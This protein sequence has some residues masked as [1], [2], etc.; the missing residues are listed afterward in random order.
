MRQSERIRGLT[1]GGSDGWDVFLKARR[2]IAQGIAVTELTIGEHDVRTAAPILQEMHRTAIGGHTGYAAVPGTA[3]LRDT[4][5]AR[6]QARTGV[7]TTRDNVV[8]TP[9]GQAALFAAHMAACDPGDTALYIDPYYA[10]YPGTLRGAGAVPQAIRTRAEDAF[11]PRAEALRAHSA[12]AVSLLINTPNNPTGVVYS[13]ATLNVVA[14]ICRE[15]DLWLIS[16][17]VY[18]TQVW[19]GRHVSPRALPGMA[20]RTL[21]VGSMSKSHA[22]TGS[23]CG[24]IVGPEAVI[25]DLITLATHTT[26]GVPGY[27]QDASEFALTRG[28]RFE[29]EI[30]APFRRRREIAREVIARQNTVGLIPAQGAMYLMLDV[31]ATGMTGEAFAYDLLDTHRIAVM[32]GESFGASAAGH[33]RVAM[34][35]EDAAFRQA[36]ET[37]CRHA[38]RRAA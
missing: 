5:A 31:R 28:E 13:D 34:T 16:D 2:M 3:S 8:I 30:A 17:E 35:I 22:M 18:D 11:Q 32:P 27:I 14:E 12:N 1:G 21:V 7:P 33:I 24:W 20:E 38:E 29:A 36:L 19:E 6:V 10:T 26:Y 37:L 23:R 15:D 25:A 4:V 9:G